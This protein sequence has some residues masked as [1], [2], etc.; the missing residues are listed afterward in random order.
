MIGPGELDELEVGRDPKD[1]AQEEQQAEGQAGPLIRAA[2][3]RVAFPRKS[4]TG[5]GRRKTISTATAAKAAASPP[6][7]NDESRSALPTSR[8]PIVP[9]SAA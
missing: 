6:Q 5:S 2:P 4:I 3:S 7:K 9:L 8:A 1:A